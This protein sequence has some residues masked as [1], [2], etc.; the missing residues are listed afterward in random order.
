MSSTEGKTE[1]LSHLE[2]IEN[3]QD[4]YKVNVIKK[5]QIQ[6]QAFWCITQ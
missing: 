4:L 2:A 1:A 5:F 3:E 6:A